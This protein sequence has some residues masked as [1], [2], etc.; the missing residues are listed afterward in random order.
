[1]RNTWIKHKATILTA[2]LVAAVLTGAFFWGGNYP[3]SA[4]AATAGVS[5]VVKHED[6]KP[7]DSTVSEAAASKTGNTPSEDSFAHLNAAAPSADKS[8]ISE[9]ADGAKPAEAQASL[10]ETAGSTGHSGAQGM[11]IKPQTGQDPYKTDPVPPADPV[12]VEPQDAT[13]TDQKGTCTLSVSCKTVLD[14]M[15]LLEEDKWELVAEDGVIFAEKSVTFYEGESVFNVLQREMKKAGIQMEFKNTPIYNSAYIAGIGNLYEFD[16]G[17][18]S[19]WVYEVNGWFP[20][21]GCSRYQLQD[22]DVIQWHFTCDLGK[23]IG[24]NNATGS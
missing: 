20:N 21:Y 9:E 5:D 16:A 7:A 10:G 23:D 6:E 22:G 1:M 4:D 14:H 13:I 24:G 2:I 17:E 12:P 18:L 3:K 15:D 19:G 11:G 8:G